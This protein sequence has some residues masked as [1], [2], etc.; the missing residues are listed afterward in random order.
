MNTLHPRA[1][2][3]TGRIIILLALLIAF[4]IHP[5]QPAQ[6]STYGDIAISEIMYDPF[7]VEEEPD[8]W[9][10][11]YNPGSAS[12][13]VSGWVLTDDNTYPS[14]AGGEGECAIPAGTPAIPAGGFL[15]V[16]KS[17]ATGIAGAVQCT[18]QN[19]TFALA[20][21]GG[22]NLALYNPSNERV[23]GSLTLSFPDISGVN[24][25]DSIGLKAPTAGW[26]AAPN[27]WAVETTAG[28]GNYLHH[29]A[30]VRN[31]GWAGNLTT[32]NNAI[33][34][35]GALNVGSEWGASEQLGSADGISFY[36]T[37]N[38]SAI[39]VGL[40]GGNATPN[41]D[42]YVV[43]IDT[44]PDN[45]GSGNTGT[46]GEY[47]GATFGANG[48]PNYA[49][50]LYND[51]TVHLT[52]SQAD[53]AGTGWMAWSPSGGTTGDTSETNP[54]SAEF[55]IQKSD[56]GLS[57]A[58]PVGLYLYACNS[59]N[60]VWAA[61]PPENEINTSA[62]VGLTTRT[63]FNG[64]GA[65]RAPRYDAARIGYH[66]LSAAAAGTLF[67]FDDAPLAPSGYDYYLRL[68]VAVGGGVGC[69]VEV[70]VIGN[71]LISMQDGGARRAYDIN[72]I[73][74][75]G[76]LA[77]VVVKYENGNANSYAS[78]DELRGI[79]EGNLQL[80][81][82]TGSAWSQVTANVRDATTRRIGVTTTAQTQ[83]DLTTR[84]GIGDDLGNTPTAITLRALTAESRARAPW[85]LTAAGVGLL[86]VGGALLRSRRRGARRF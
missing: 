48:K 27:D 47:C 62:V 82:F 41:S 38:A 46:I 66:T 15:V 43:L 73:G 3:N 18:E 23:F 86:L 59:G 24:S 5:A 11:L 65:D 72:P 61:W 50:Q 55:A 54:G 26:S 85:L 71:R 4:L 60:R 16:A 51:G 31:D 25:G 17:N 22:D 21:T 84:W 34:I 79:V 42:K 53:G 39:Y 36:V 56:L 58:S 14:P 33:T 80:Y 28:S 1:W 64:T 81:R 68:G 49:L 7:G 19:G 44:D 67:F 75:T 78:P 74:C 77:T 6:A 57:S 35:D 52:S 76:L 10:E 29:T 40:V 9:V 30:G 70:K 45:T 63:V 20:S 69:Q 12:V 83:S 8:E 37:W 32:Y 13:D 2:K